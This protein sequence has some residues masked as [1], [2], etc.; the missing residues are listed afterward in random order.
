VVAQQVYSE[1]V[2]RGDVERELEKQPFWRFRRRQALQRA[3]LQIRS[4]ETG[5][6]ELLGGRPEPL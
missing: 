3:L 5:G 2:R 1:Y 4:A 6:V